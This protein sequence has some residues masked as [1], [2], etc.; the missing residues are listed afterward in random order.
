MVLVSGA[1]NVEEDA[2]SSKEVPTLVCLRLLQR[3]L[4]FAD[5]VVSRGTTGPFDLGCTRMSNDE[6]RQPVTSR[7]TL[8]GWTGKK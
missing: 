3:P 8:R 2:F 7:L 5:H 4:G 6:L 1:F